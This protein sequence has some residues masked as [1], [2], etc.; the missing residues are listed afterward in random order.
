MAAQATGG[1]F[2]L[3]KTGER[4]IFLPED[5]SDEQRQL[6]DL[7]KNFIQGEVLPRSEDIE[8]QKFDVTVGLLKKAGEL[9]L[10]AAEVPEELGGLAI[11][12]VST[13]AMGENSIYQGS[14][15][16][17]LMC[18]TGIGSW[19][20]MYFGTPEQKKKYLTKLAT[21]EMIGAYCLTEPC[22]GSDALGMKSKA[23]PSADGKSWVLNGEKTFITNGGFADL[24]TIFAKTEGDKT[25]AFL[26]ERGTPGLSTGK[27]EKKMGIKGSSTTPVVMENCVIPKENLLGE[28]G[29]GHKIA[30]NILNLGRFKLGVGATGASKYLIGEA[31]KYAKDRKQFGKSITDFGLIRKKLA[32][33]A[34]RTFVS[35]SMNYRTADLMDQKIKALAKGDASY[36]QK[37]MEIVEEFAIES[38]IAKIYGSE[39]VDMVADEGLQILGGYGFLEEYPFA[40][41]LRNTRINRI[42]EGTN[43]I[44][45]LLIPAMLFKAAMKGQL[46]LMNAISSVVGQ[47]KEGWKKEGDGPLADEIHQVELAKKLTIYAAGCAAQKFMDQLRD[48]QYI[49]EY[50]ADLAVETYAMET[51]VLR[52][53]QLRKRFGDKATLAE[54]IMKLFV[55]EA[56]PE[57]LVRARRLL[58]A[59]AEGNQEEF[60]KY[61][62]AL[63]RFDYFNPVDTTAL[64]DG[65]AQA[66]ID[67]E[68]YRIV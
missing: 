51:A 37:V 31:V 23:V 12:K 46:E 14:F 59:V 3:E 49:A 45:R 16:V 67:R 39:C 35:E 41:A 22:S 57:M 5:L 68:G 61:A 34:S 27:E 33:M 6:A 40:A 10:L 54:S 28:I 60:G 56:Y 58:L 2:L 17:S 48:K 38:S 66:V 52:A 29:K 9:G 36:D 4:E 21:G 63:T 24:Y 1:S 30:F 47:L 7:V 64:R 8:H 53:V 43:E 55:N 25:T 50:I 20:I 19:P 62:K 13:V 32:N 65:I 18:H 26:V 15:S 11:N 42:F 44:N